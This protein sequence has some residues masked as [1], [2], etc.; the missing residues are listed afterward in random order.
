LTLTGSLTFFSD[1]AAD[2]GRG[3]S[4]ALSMTGSINGVAAGRIGTFQLDLDTPDVGG[5]AF[6]QNVD[7]IR[8][9]PRARHADAARA[10]RRGVGASA[11]AEGD[12][13]AQVTRREKLI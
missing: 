2:L 12:G 6:A 8:A 1:R 10:G 11:L 4:V 7:L 3:A 13:A 5:H 9:D